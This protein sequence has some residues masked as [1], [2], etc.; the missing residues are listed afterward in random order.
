ML[1]AIRLLNIEDPQIADDGVVTFDFTVDSPFPYAI[2][3]AQS[4]VN[5]NGFG[6]SITN[7]GNVEFWPVIKMYGDGGTIYNATTNQT[8]Q[9]GSGCLGGGTYIEID[10]FRNTAYVDGDQANAKPCLDPIITEFFPLNPGINYINSTAS[11]DFL[12]NDAFA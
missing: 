8:I 12:V 2:S 4:V 3:V 9:I 7:N 1:N 5:I 11:C 6:G 10:A